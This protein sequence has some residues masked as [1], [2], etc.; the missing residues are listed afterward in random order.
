[1]ST[2]NLT[3][4]HRRKN[5]LTGDYVLVSPHRNNRPWLGATEQSVV[6]N[7]P[8][9][10]ENCPLCPSNIR[11]NNEINP[12]YKDT[13]V[14]LNDFGALT[15]DDEKENTA[16]DELFHV[17][18]TQG[19]CHVVCYSPQHNKSLA[20][21]SVDDI[22]RVIDTWQS[23]YQ[24]L[25]ERYQCVHV[26]ENKGSVMG[27]SQPHPHGQI[28]AHNHLSTEI[29]SENANQLDY[30][31]RH[32]SA[33]LAD[34]VVKEQ[35]NGSRTLYENEHWF[36]VVP[37]W[38]AWP[39]ETMILPK[40]NIASFNQL[41]QEHKVSLAQATKA[42]T[43]GYDKLFNCSFPYSMGWHSAPESGDANEH[44]R[45]HGHFYPPL[46]RSATVK[47]FMVGYE[48]MAEAQ[49]DLTPEAA[50]ARLREVMEQQ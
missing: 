33:L 48:M 29:E 24:S 40:A 44:W 34:Y 21:M 16:S 2:D 1:M 49:R 8:S 47:K 9:F 7:T 41:S 42:I 19:E 30:Y 31:N 6:D 28:W 4:V 38:A 22:T 43:A 37:F 26:F 10:D 46:L 25:S 5:P 39:F 17:E 18:H 15:T 36:V 12:D 50:A 35:N 23:H 20:Q 32:G 14:F 3:K 11:A 45:L 27:C 13:F